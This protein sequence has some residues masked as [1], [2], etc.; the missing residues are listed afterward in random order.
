MPA[1]VRLCR[2]EALFPRAKRSCA[3]R[4]ACAGLERHVHESSRRARAAPA[5]RRRRD[6]RRHA[7]SPTRRALPF[8]SVRLGA[9]AAVVF[10]PSSCCF[11]DVVRA[12]CAMAC[13]DGATN[14]HAKRSIRRKTSG[15]RRVR[16]RE[17]RDESGCG[18]CCCC[19]LRRGWQL[20]EIQ[21]TFENRKRAQ[22]SPRETST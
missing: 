18:S 1:H 15:R 21:A 19:S 10:F 6:A 14:H 13:C 7:C 12:A 17:W 9:T 16:T 4:M 5:K 2:F 3:C 11:V 8:S 20:W 22:T